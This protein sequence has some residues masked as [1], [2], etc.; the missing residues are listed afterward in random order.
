M[1]HNYISGE[2]NEGGISFVSDNFFATNNIR[3][4]SGKTVVGIDTDNKLIK[5]TNGT[6]SFDKL[7]LATGADSTPL[8][9]VQSQNPKNVLGLRHLHDAKAIRERAKD[10]NN[11]VIIGAGLVG[12]DA[13]YALVNMGKKPTVVDMEDSI[14]T[15]N[16]DL[17]TANVYKQK[18][19]EA[20]C[21]FKLGRKVSQV[22]INSAGNIVSLTLNSNEKLPCDLVIV[23][24]GARP[25]IGFLEDS[26]VNCDNSIIVDKY[27][28]TNIEG[29][30]AAGDVTGLSG[31]WSNAVKQ[32]EVAANNMCGKSVVYDDAFAIKNT[33]NYFA[34]PSLS[35]GKTEPSFGDVLEIREDRNNYKK[36]ILRDGIVAGVILQ[37]CIAH[38]GFWQFLIRNRVNISQANSYVFDISFADFYGLQ[39]NGEFQWIITS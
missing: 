6:E 10:A 27:L 33:I 37:G 35:L 20:G 13:A 17:H 22:D 3:W 18:F 11:I 7:L 19:E 14:L 38:S 12:L 36:V 21:T 16:L 24:I 26:K 32:G 1:L 23:A 39:E 4:I 28:S 30:Y 34:I 8:P 9:I 31:I 25:A 29:I 2:R 5:F 15:L